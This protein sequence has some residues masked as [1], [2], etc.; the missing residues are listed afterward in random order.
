[1]GRSDWKKEEIAEW[2]KKAIPDLL[3]EAASVHR[4]FHDPL[5]IKLNTLISV[6]TGACSEDCA[7]CAQSA[8][9]S[10]GVKPS[11]LDEETVLEQAERAKELGATRI[12]LSAS[13]REASSRKQ[14]DELIS[15]AGKIREMGLNVCCTLGM[16]NEEGASV[17][18]KAGFSA[19]NHNLDTSERYYPTIVTTRKYSDRLNTIDKL[20][21]SEMPFCSGGIIGMGETEDDRISLIHTLATRKIHPYSV[22]YNL[23]VP[24]KGTPLQ[25]VLG[26]ADALDMVRMIATSRIVMPK[27]IICLAAGRES[28]SE[29]AQTLCFFAG[30]NSVFIGE[31]LLTAPNAE[32]SKDIALFNKLGIRPETNSDE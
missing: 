11:F 22:P 23:L 21:Q 9:Y 32:P 19:Y 15:M 30:A 5:K 14:V 8:R 7:Y 3:F 20:I 12:C 25:N 10:T 24:V 27:S 6:K 13:W 26:K 17:L 31:K 4:A 29:E 18:K 1:M 28:L 16:I 2:Y